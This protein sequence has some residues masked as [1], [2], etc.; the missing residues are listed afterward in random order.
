VITAAE[1]VPRQAP[2]REIAVVTG[3][4]WVIAAPAACV[5][6]AA[7]LPAASVAFWWD[8]ATRTGDPLR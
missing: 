8:A 5:L 1:V 6:F 3:R 7:G 4:R 2:D